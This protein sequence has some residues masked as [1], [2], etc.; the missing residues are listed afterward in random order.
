[1]EPQRNRIEP[2][3]FDLAR[4]LA[5]RR[6]LEDIERSGTLPA[7]VSALDATEVVLCTLEVRL[8]RARAQRIVH[9]IPPT[10]AALISSCV[11]RQSDPRKTTLDEGGLVRD[12][13]VTLRM[14]LDRAEQLA[15]A[16]F[17]AVQKLMPPQEIL[18]VRA[19]LAPRVRDLWY[20][21]GVEEP[22]A[23]TPPERAYAME[24]GR[25]T[26]EPTESVLREIDQSGTLPLE[27][28]AAEVLQ[29]VLCTLSL[30]LTAHEAR[31][32]ANASRS[33][34]GLLMPCVNHRGERP[35][36]TREPVFLHVLAEHLGIDEGR[37]GRIARTVFAALRGRLPPDAIQMIDNRIP[38]SVR[39]LWR[40]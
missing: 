3:R 5:T 17:C 22:I 32:L 24:I 10:L 35:E 20:P 16:V 34:R 25:P 21:L 31:E 1:M 4:D 8:P 30:E 13:A 29:A 7:H 27:L 38:R 9:D 36:V 28:S 14:S 39:A 18:A 11:L 6:L 23:A 12:V 33:L 19:R 26:E 37:A 2:A 15:R 40:T